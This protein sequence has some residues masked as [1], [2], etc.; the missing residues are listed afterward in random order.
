MPHVLAVAAG[1]QR[2]PIPHLVLVEGH[3]GALHRYMV[4]AGACVWSARTSGGATQPE[5]VLGV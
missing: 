2:H 3:D 1:E 5:D 4:L